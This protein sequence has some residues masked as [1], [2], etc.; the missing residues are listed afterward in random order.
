MSYLRIIVAQK[1]PAKS[2][3]KQKRGTQISGYNRFCAIVSRAL[4]I[5]AKPP[6]KQKRGTQ[7]CVPLK[8]KEEREK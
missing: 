2:L 6:G 1:I 5:P 4:K 7:K 8:A 3:G